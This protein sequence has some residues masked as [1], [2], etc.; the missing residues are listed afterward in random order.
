[1]RL[2]NSHLLNDF[3]RL[4]N[5]APA[6]LIQIEHESDYDQLV[7]NIERTGYYTAGYFDQ[8]IGY[9]KRPLKRENLPVA[10]MALQLNPT[11]VL[12]LGCGR[13]DVLMLLKLA[14]VEDVTG[15]D[16]S[17]DVLEHLP[18]EL[19][20]KVLVGD[21]L[22][23]IPALKKGR[24]R[25][26]LIMAFDLW[27]HLH[28]AKLEEYLR[29]VDLLASDNALFLFIVP[30]FGEDRVYG[31]PFPLQFEE[32]RADFDAGRL[33]SYLMVE[34]DDPPIPM[35]GHLIWA[36]GS[37]W[38]V[39]FRQTGWLR[40]TGVEK[41]LHEFFDPYLGSAQR[42]F[43]IFRKDSP[44]AAQRARTLL[45]NPMSHLQL[46]RSQLRFVR[47]VQDYHKRTGI[48]LMDLDELL[49]HLDDAVFRMQD[50]LYAEL[51]SVRGDLHAAHQGIQKLAAELDKP[52]TARQILS[53]FIP[54]SIK[55]LLRG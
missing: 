17:R 24:G 16:I 39:R 1:M 6:K 5:G 54:Q 29:Q 41:N 19:K 2:I 20:E 10:S 50:N 53:L 45:E 26:D 55:R 3:K 14:G 11:K 36:P 9:A 22:D 37:W 21:L 7:E 28:P 15:L 51:H 35:N 25:F 33:F 8:N 12:E 48:E 49:R 32:N 46:W 34:Q 27:E 4:N 40:E 47:A 52:L 31:E 18:T 13:G 42:S 44:K 38:E 30:A 23:T 43:Y